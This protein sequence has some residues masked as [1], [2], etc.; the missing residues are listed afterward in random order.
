MLSKFLKGF[1]NQTKK[2]PAAKEIKSKATTWER[3][4]LDSGR[5]SYIDIDPLNIPKTNV[6]GFL[7]K[8]KK[9]A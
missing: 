4:A 5:K 6:S 2:L 9:P 1:Y 8:G 3:M 7:Y